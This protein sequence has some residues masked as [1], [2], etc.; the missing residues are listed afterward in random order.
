M[1]NLAPGQGR[2]KFQPQEYIEYF[3]VY[4]FDLTPRWGQRGHC[5]T[6]SEGQALRR[7]EKGHHRQ[8]TIPKP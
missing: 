7:P 5:Y 4:N 6:A 2:S 3:E 1:F 8:N